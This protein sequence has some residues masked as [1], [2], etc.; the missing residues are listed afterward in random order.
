M[1]DTTLRETRILGRIEGATNPESA[2]LLDDGETLVFGNCTMVVGNPNQR[3]G[4]ALV[5][6]EGQAFITQ[7]KI[8]GEGQVDV[9]QR[10]L[11]DG[12]TGTLGSEVHRTGT[13]LWPAGTALTA[14]G[15]RPYSATPHGPMASIEDARQQILAFDP[16]TGEQ[17]GR[18][19]LWA[20]SPIA[21]ALGHHVEMPNGLAVAPNGDL[22]V[23]DNPNSNPHAAEP[24]PVPSCVYR[25]P[26]ESIDGLIEDD[27]DAAATVQAVEW[28]GWFNGVAASPVDGAAWVVTCSMHDPHKGAVIR[29]DADD[30]AAGRLPEPFIA[31]LGILDGVAVSRRGTV[32]ATNPLTKDVFVFPT[33]GSR[34]R[35]VIDGDTLPMTNPADVNVIYPNF[36]D[37]EPALAVGDIC[38]G[39]KPE[40]AQVLILDITSL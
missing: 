28:S 27:P 14:C 3:G 12:L 32:F 26:F 21:L 16:V 31:D 36:L 1:I 11:V 7:A 23:A 20:G 35:L 37:S 8:R 38:V 30:F 9:T 15:G 34:Q 25:V 13:K 10:R 17:R 39:G 22:Y 5:Y 33:D 29:L 6:L 24:P 19:A 4:E 18:V 2:E 40:T